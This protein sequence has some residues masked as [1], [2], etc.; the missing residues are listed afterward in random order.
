MVFQ[1]I[2]GTDQPP[3]LIQF[4]PAQHLL[5]DMHMAFMGR[6]EGSA[7]QADPLAALHMGHAQIF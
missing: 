1:W 5:A 7:E 2:A 4:Q 3:D 6:I